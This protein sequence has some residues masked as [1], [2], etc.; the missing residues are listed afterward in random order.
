MQVE[1][2][3]SAGSPWMPV[4]NNKIAVVIDVFRAT[5]TMV[6]ALANGCQ[7]L[8]PVLTVEEAIERK[9]SEPEALLGGER[10]ALPIEGFDLGNSPYD[11]V[12]EKV[13]GKK[14][15]MTTTNGTRAIQAVSKAPF[16]TMAS[17]LN[18]ES[19]AHSIL[20]RIKQSDNIEGIVILCAGSE[21]RFDIP[22]TLCAGM[23]IDE[24][25]QEIETND[26]GCA[27]H[28]LYDMAKGNLQESM[29]NTEHGRL[30]LSLG[31]EK[32]VIYCSTPNILPIVPVLRQGEVVWHTDTDY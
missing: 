3:P 28:M 7:A 2:L 21:D 24:L 1:V 23:L 25:G 14:V 9:N 29:K 16:I 19:V 15:I 5:S 27:S 6:T 22:D 11:Y 26:L 31:F 17:F 8:I 4:L 12:P 13:G 10:K 20:K 32:D 18:V 30:L